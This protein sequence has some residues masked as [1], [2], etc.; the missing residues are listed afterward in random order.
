MHVFLLNSGSDALAAP[1]LRWCERCIPI[2]RVRFFYFSSLLRGIK[3]V[4]FSS[5]THIMPHQR[6]ERE[7]YCMK[8]SHFCIYFINEMNRVCLLPAAIDLKIVFFAQDASERVRTLDLRTNVRVAIRNDI[9]LENMMYSFRSAE[10]EQKETVCKT[11]QIN[12]IGLKSPL[13]VPLPPPPPRG[14][15]HSEHICFS[16]C[17]AHQTPWQFANFLWPFSFFNFARVLADGG[18]GSVPVS[19]CRKIYC[20]AFDGIFVASA[21]CSTYTHS[22]SDAKNPPKTSVCM[23][24]AS[25]GLADEAGKRC[26]IY[27]ENGKENEKL[28][29]IGLLLRQIRKEKEE[30]SRHERRR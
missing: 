20:L 16:Y 6:P 13:A 10:K 14:I 21:K 12:I 1:S 7:T 18:D 26:E 24:H 29:L 22:S 8:I 3:S 19:L 23:S 2:L 25:I 28:L 15:T 27:L 5:T 17:A 4:M 11:T 9:S 30:F